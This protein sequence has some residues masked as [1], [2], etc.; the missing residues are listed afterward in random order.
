MTAWYAAN[1]STPSNP[2]VASAAGG[3]HERVDELE[4]L[5]LRHR[6]AAVSVVIRGQARR[7]PV[8]RERVVGVAVL[9]DVVQLVDHDDVAVG[10]IPTRIR[11][12]PEPGNDRIVVD[13]EVAAREHGGPMHRHRLD[14]DHAG[15]AERTFPVV[16][17]VA[18]GDQTVL[19]HVGGVG[20]EVDP[21]AQRAVAQLQRSEDVGE[22]VRA[23]WGVHVAAAPPRNQ[24]SAIVSA[25]I[26]V[27]MWVLT[28]G[29]SANTDASHTNNPL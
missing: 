22:G 3:A 6:V 28:S 2:D 20:A 5:G 24:R 10:G 18:I 16:G 13:S 25:S 17:D 21:A 15:T 27:G 19:A 8:R 14:D 7:R 12:S 4:D 11:Q 23:G 29:M 26:T 9:T 1:S